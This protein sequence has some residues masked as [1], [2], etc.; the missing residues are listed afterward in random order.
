MGILRAVQ[1][2]AGFITGH[3]YNDKGQ[4]LYPPPGK[5]GGPGTW[6]QA[7]RTA[8]RPPHRSRRQRRVRDTYV[9]VPHLGWL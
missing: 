7:Q 5:N 8:P 2:H 6:T 1:H 4:C 9:G 3:P